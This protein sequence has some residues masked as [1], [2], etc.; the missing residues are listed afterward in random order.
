MQEWWWLDGQAIPFH[1]EGR[2]GGLR[3]LILVAFGI[4]TMQM[5]PLVT[6]NIHEALFLLSSGDSSRLANEPGQAEG[7]MWS[8]FILSFH[9]PTLLFPS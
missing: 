6:M 3:L 1:R 7:G 4:W 5:R 9:S 2:Q 8:L